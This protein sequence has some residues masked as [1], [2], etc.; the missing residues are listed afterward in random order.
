MYEPGWEHVTWPLPR[1]TYIPSHNA[2]RPP[3][4]LARRVQFWTF[5]FPFNLSLFSLGQQ[6]CWP[7]SI[8]G[9]VAIFALWRRLHYL[10]LSG[11]DPDKMISKNPHFLMLDF[12]NY[13]VS[14]TWYWHLNL[15][16]S[17]LVLGCSHTFFPWVNKPQNLALKAE[18]YKEHNLRMKF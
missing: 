13:F 12:H 18:G 4:F 11:I 8:G 3:V 5:F 6:V 1:S 16:N 7:P 2:S 10:N 15:I 9:R 14:K 17:Q